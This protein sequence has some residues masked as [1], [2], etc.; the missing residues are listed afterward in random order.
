MCY[1]IFCIVESNW[2]VDRITQRVSEWLSD[3]SEIVTDWVW[4]NWIDVTQNQWEKNENWTKWI[5]LLLV[6]R[7]STREYASIWFDFR[8]PECIRHTISKALICIWIFENIKSNESTKHKFHVIE[9]LAV[10]RS[11]NLFLKYP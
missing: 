3:S 7:I 11:F 5:D 9:V 2:F 6:C 1:S 8:Y 10:Q 4:E